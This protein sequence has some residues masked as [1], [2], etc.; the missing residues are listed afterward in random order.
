MQDARFLNDVAADG[1]GR[2]Y[3]SD[4]GTSAI[5]RLADGKLE[6]WLDGPQLKYPN[7]LL[8]QGDKLIVAAW[9]APKTQ[10]KTFAAAN[11]FEISLKDKSVRDL[12]SGTPIGN[13]DG[14]EPD[15]PDSY[16][17][18]G[19]GGGRRLPRRRHGQGRSGARPRSG[20]RRH[21]HDAGRAACC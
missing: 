2:V 4:F 13:L 12:G 11:L 7:G 14:I 3:V 10:D 6:K 16:L 21:R 20:Q 8:V 17:R 9:G 1:E 18:H 19:L 15:G 5:W